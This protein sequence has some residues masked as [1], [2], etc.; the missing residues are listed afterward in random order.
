MDCTEIP[1][2]TCETDV[3]I[4]KKAKCID[5]PEEVCDMVDDDVCT[6]RTEKRC[7]RCYGNRQCCKDVP[8]KTC[9]KQQKR[10]CK[11]VPKQYCIDVPTVA[12]NKTCGLDLTTKCGTRVNDQCLTV[13]RTVCGAEPREICVD[14]SETQ[15][16][17]TPREITKQVCSPR[18]RQQCF[19]VRYY[20]SL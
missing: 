11:F 6:E 17:V 16:T 14:T 12:A 8:I 15:C 10:V 19:A 1:I 18:P 4:G 9:K 5:V 13:D 2:N 7:E 3:E 20:P